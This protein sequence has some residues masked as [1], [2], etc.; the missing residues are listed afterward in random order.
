[1]AGAGVA[2][3]W[4]ANGV[5]RGAG[6][7]EEVGSWCEVREVVGAGVVGLGRS[8]ARD[9]DGAGV[10]V[11]AVEGHVG[12]LD[13][14]AGFVDDA[15]AEIGLRGEP[16]DEGFGIDA[17]AGDDGGGVAAVRVIARGEVAGGAAFEDVRS[18]GDAGEGEGSVGAG[19]DGV[20]ASDRSCR[21]GSGWWR[22]GGGGRRWR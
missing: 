13:G 11:F 3:G 8:G 6:G 15:A 10:A 12:A 1:M 17:G 5:P 4:G 16:E 9:V 18:G 20:F 19:D 2:G 7:G 22:A 14:V 21:G